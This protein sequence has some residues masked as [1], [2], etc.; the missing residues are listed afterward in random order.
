MRQW[1]Q[2]DK[3]QGHIDNYLDQKRHKN[4]KLP[5]VTNS[6][7]FINTS[8]PPSTTGGFRKF[9]FDIKKQSN[10]GFTSPVDP[11]AHQNY[12]P[13]NIYGHKQKRIRDD[14]SKS[15]DYNSNTQFMFNV[16]KPFTAFSK[17]ENSGSLENSQILSQNMG[18]FQRRN[19]GNTKDLSFTSNSNQQMQQQQ[20]LKFSF[21]RGLSEATKIYSA[22]IS[23][24]YLDKIIS[25]RRS[26]NQEEISE[27]SKT[28]ITKDM[29]IEL[30]QGRKVAKNYSNLAT[31][32][33][34]NSLST[35]L[36]QQFQSPGTKTAQASFSIQSQSTQKQQHNY[37]QQREQSPY[38]VSDSI[39]MM[40]A[41]RQNQFQKLSKQV[42]I[43]RDKI[44]RIP[45]QILPLN[46][47]NLNNIISEDIKEETQRTYLSSRLNSKLINISEDNQ[48]NSSYR[49]HTLT[50]QQKTHRSY[51]STED[52]QQIED[53]MNKIACTINKLNS[54][55]L[56]YQSDL[57]SR[58]QDPLVKKGT[59]QFSQMSNSG[60]YDLEQMIEFKDEPLMR[61][62]YFQ[63]ENKHGKQV[64]NYYETSPKKQENNINSSSSQLEVYEIESLIS[65]VQNN[66]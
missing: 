36:T 48:Q 54:Q 64:I 58:R 19:Q 10:T 2:I 24:N 51:I 13:A 7:I 9:N 34:Q 27:K 52:G 14:K 63:Q 61:S 56:K 46:L 6:D 32:T 17:R 18:F 40:Q 30:R 16:E 35:N 20:Q 41:R 39:R 26:K 42:D 3:E 28:S 22:K 60:G 31:P 25:K 66:E 47:I 29:L 1:K 5:S 12:S 44:R 55:F 43:K 57:N 49:Q 50:N 33:Q 23:V 53:R 65:M 4:F 21:N 38:Q 15:S 62:S 59:G 45:Q 11:Y 8:K 37:T